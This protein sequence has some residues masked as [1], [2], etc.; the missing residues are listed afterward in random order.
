M[1]HGTQGR[2]H[3][4][5]EILQES[6]LWQVSWCSEWHLRQ[7]AA[8]PKAPT[9]LAPRKWSAAVN[10]RLSEGELRSRPGVAT[11]HLE[12][13]ALG[14]SSRACAGFCGTDV[15]SR[16]SGARCSVSTHTGASY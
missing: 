13:G 10:N 3:R 14:D 5:Q 8:G 4:P 6:V 16:L 15:R 2:G 1:S 9:S 11:Y 7:E 12:L